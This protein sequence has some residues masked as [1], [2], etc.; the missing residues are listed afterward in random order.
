MFMGIPHLIIK[1]DLAFNSQKGFF[2]L[3]NERIMSPVCFGENKGRKK[4]V[5]NLEVYKNQL[6]SIFKSHN[7]RFF[8]LVGKR[9]W[10]V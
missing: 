3:R 4:H 8:D 5:D 1:E 6:I 10:L 2:C 9:F 7:E